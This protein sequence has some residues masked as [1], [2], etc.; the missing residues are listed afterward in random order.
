[1]CFEFGFKCGEIISEDVR[2]LRKS[3]TALLPME[4][5]VQCVES[6]AAPCAAICWYPKRNTPLAEIQ[7]ANIQTEPCSL[8]G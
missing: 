7:K 8:S 6:N 4:P 3:G 5:R 1:M 2:Y